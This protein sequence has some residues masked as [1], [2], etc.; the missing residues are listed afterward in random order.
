MNHTSL[1]PAL[2]T[3]QT[4]LSTYNLGFA[5]LALANGLIFWKARCRV[6]T[7]RVMDVTRSKSSE[8]DCDIEIAKGRKRR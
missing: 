1:P 6:R 7:P 5:A 2:E 3:V 4:I 8:Y